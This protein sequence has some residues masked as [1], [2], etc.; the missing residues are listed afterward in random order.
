MRASKWIF[1]LMG[2]A[3]GCGGDETD[4]PPDDPEDPICVAW[5]EASL[6]PNCSAN[7]NL[8]ACVDDCVTDR[9]QNPE[10]DAEYDALLV[11]QTEGGF[12][13]DGGIPRTIGDCAAEL[14]ANNA[15]RAAN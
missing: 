2:L 11:C 6:E 13:C 3:A 7:S 5:C 15:C 8:A 9:E 12:I 4:P 1:V 10:C 14:N